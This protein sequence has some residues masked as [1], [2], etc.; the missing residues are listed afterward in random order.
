MK[1]TVMGSYFLRVVSL[2]FAFSYAV[3]IYSELA[4]ARPIEEIKKSGQLR[5][6]VE[7][8]FIPFEMKLSNGEWIGFDVDMME[9]FAKQIGVK[10]SFVD[11]K[12]DGIIPALM[13]GKFDLIVSGMTITEERKKAVLFSDPYYDAGLLVM[14]SA[15]AK[16]RFQKLSDLDKPNIK[17][18]VKQGTTG[19]IF[20][21]KTI[22]S[23]SILKLESEADAANSVL[24]GKVDAFIYDKPFLK[25]FAGMKDSKAALLE[26]L[27]SQEQFGA[28]ARPQ[29]KNLIASFNEFLKAWRSAGG[30]AAAMDKHFVQMPWKSKIE[31]LW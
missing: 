30:Y 1:N 11:T 21:K 22:K 14:I 4:Q 8:G 17:I 6:G 29:D 24:L 20:A 10:V 19:D 26:D 25:L 31:K 16:D 3:F 5:I 18:A 15:G 28:A 7:P 13:A 9:A 12:W 27:L 23:A 2:A